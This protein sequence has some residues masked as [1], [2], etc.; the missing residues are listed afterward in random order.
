MFVYAQG[1]GEFQ[2]TEISEGVF[3]N[4]TETKKIILPHSLIKIEWSFWKCQKLESIEVNEIRY[5][6]KHFKSI[7]GVLYTALNV[8]DD[9]I[10]LATP[11]DS[12]VVKDCYNLEEL[13]LP[14]TLEHI[15]INAFYR[16]ENLKRIIVNRKNGSIKIEG[17]WG[18]YGN[19]TP[20]WYWID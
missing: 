20:K 13:T 3:E 15:G 10:S 7:D 18:D 6:R 5:Q 11:E 19:V 8:S 4:L 14:S 2:V 12:I 1:K 16:C 17:F 9:A